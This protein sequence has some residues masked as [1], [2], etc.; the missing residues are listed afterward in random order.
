MLSTRPVSD[1]SPDASRAT[2]FGFESLGSLL[3]FGALLALL[4]L[5]PFSLSGFWATTYDFWP[6]A[7]FLLLGAGAALLL[8]ISPDA[9]FGFDATATL[10]LVFLVWNLVSALTGVYHHDAWLELARIFGAFIVF[11]AVRALWKPSRALWIVGAWILGMTWICIPALSDFAQTHYPRQAGPFFNT[12]LFAN[13]LAMTLPMAL[14]F[15]VLLARATKNQVVLT[16]GALPFLI[17][18]FGLI[19][20]S[21]KGG[22]LAAIVAL[23]VTITLIFCAKA[24]SIRIFAR[25]NRAVLM[26]ASLIFL[27]LFGALAAKTIVPRLQSARGSDD[28]STMFRAY[29]WRSTLDMARAK[30]IF[31]FGPGAF[32]HVYPR[33]ARVSYTRSA[34]QSWL[35]IAAESGF[36]A[37]ILVLGAVGA[38]LKSGAARLKT[39]DWPYI[40]GA[41]GAVC[42]LLV[43]GCVDSGFQTTSI[44]ILFAVALAILTA[45]EKLEE[46]SSETPPETRKSRLN[47]W[48][49][50]ATLLL[51]LGGNQTQ[52]AASGEDVRFRAVEF[53]RN[54]APTI[55]SQKMKEAVAIDPTSARLWLTLGRLQAQ[56]GDNGRAALQTAAQLQPSNATNWTNLARLSERAGDAPAAIE[57]FYARALENDP[58]NTSILLEHAQ[59]RLA[60]KN[61][62]G[63]DDLQKIIALRAQPYGLYAPVE[64]IVD[65]D[66]ARATL[67]I[68]PEFKR[69]KQSAQ[70]QSLLKIGLA[71][72]ARARSFVTQNEQMR[73]ETGGEFGQSENDDL[74]TVSAA[75]QVLQTSLK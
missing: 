69:K 48:W 51:A 64:Q 52:K 35:Q 62:A 25:R 6:Q 1:A 11:F 31:G 71:D 55:S 72:C 44:V 5:A 9:R 12:N 14:I 26:V 18:A 65:L 23:F 59:F 66:F 24:A 7:I 58:L 29:I 3:A 53:A 47:P 49:L 74:E 22:F 32:P 50:G 21:S 30:P 37:L 2:S 54:G 68:A 28:N 39:R 34:H 57:K 38:A 41:T 8:A 73:R 36:P 42:A 70:L 75:L 33:F 60:S 16:L 45:R 63:Y 10:L 20:T 61:R 43:H 15:P 67:L 46:T 13:A 19:V 27:L 17:C 40:A 56:G 4:L